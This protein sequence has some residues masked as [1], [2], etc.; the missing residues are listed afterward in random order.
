MKTK[1]LSISLKDIAKAKGV[2]YRTVIRHKGKGEFFIDHANISLSL[3]SIAVYL[4]D[5]MAFKRLLQVY[6]KKN[7]GGCMPTVVEDE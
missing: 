6:K 7:L 3:L 2:N 4:C 5:N 1:N